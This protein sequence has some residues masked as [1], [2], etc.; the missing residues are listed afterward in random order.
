METCLLSDFAFTLSSC[1]VTVE[2]SGRALWPIILLWKYGEYQHAGGDSRGCVKMVTEKLN[3]FEKR[4]N[5]HQCKTTNRLLVMLVTLYGKYVAEITK[6]LPFFS[7]H[8]SIVTP[9]LPDLKPDLECI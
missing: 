3:S 8:F 2:L 5:P 9:S 7:F 4:K 1:S 6:T